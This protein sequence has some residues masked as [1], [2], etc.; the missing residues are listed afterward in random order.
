VTYGIES[1][2]DLVAEDIVQE[3]LRT[4][5]TVHRPAH[6]ESFVVRLNLPGRH[7]VQNALAA[8]AVGGELG[9]AQDLIARALSDFQGIARR[10]QLWGELRLPAAVTLVDDYGHHP[11]E[12]EA[13]L[14]AVRGAW[15]GRRVV[16][17]FQP[18]R[19]TRTRDLLEDFARVLSECDVLLLLEVYAAGEAPIAGADGRT[20]CRAV[21]ARGRVDPVFAEGPA[22]VD[23]LLVQILK[24]GDLV[25]TLGAGDIGALA[26][27]LAQRFGA[28]E[29][30]A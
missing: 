6:G 24:D 22:E 3:G 17:V 26:P 11:S 20:V 7:N 30:R 13:T 23:D 27:H 5:F 16:V 25:L 28:P 19:Y 2:A 18:H 14:A 8:I 9:I 1:D 10:M 12:I 29:L 21:R 4:R 15:P